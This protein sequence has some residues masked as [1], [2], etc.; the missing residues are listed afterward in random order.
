MHVEKTYAG[1]CTSSSKLKWKSMFF[2]R[3]NTKVFYAKKV[4]VIVQE[5][6]LCGA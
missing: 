2:L 3:K 1:T 5:P 6:D 4:H